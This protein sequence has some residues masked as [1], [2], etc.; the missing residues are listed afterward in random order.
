MMTHDE[1]VE[2]IA[3]YALDAVDQDE[4]QAIE[5]HLAECPRCRA[6]LDG[7]HNVTTALGNSVEPLPEGLWAS[8]ASRLPERS[9]RERPPMPTLIPAVAV[10]KI[11]GLRRCR[12]SAGGRS[13]EDQPR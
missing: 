6:D 2:S 5:A 11:K 3:T 8:I 4:R 9:E 7:Y 13:V 12:L 1:A 10:R